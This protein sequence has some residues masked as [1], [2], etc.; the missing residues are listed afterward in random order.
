[1]YNHSGIGMFKGFIWR[2]GYIE[3]ESSLIPHNQNSTANGLRT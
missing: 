3:N 2:I 1:M